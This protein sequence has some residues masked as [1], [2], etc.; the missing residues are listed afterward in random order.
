MY[1]KNLITTIAL[2]SILM[3][4]AWAQDE[5]VWTDRNTPAVNKEYAHADYMLFASREAALK[6]NYEDSENYILLNGLWNFN[7]ADDAR[8]LPKNFYEVNFDDSK[9]AKMQ[10]PS[11]W[12]INGYG[13]PIY[14]NS[15]FEFSPDS[16][17]NAP[18]FPDVVPGGQY[19]VKFN[20]PSRWDGR[21]VFIQ[22]GGVKSGCMVYVN[23][24]KVGYSEDSKDPAEFNITDY[25]KTGE[26]VLAIEVHRWS[27]GSYYE[28]QDFWRLSGIERDVYLTSRP[29]VLIRDIITES[30]LS[31]DYKDGELTYKVKLANYTGKANKVKLDLTVLDPA[32]NTAYT[33]S[34]TESIDPAVS[35]SNGQFVTF[36]HS[37]SNVK[38]WSAETPVLY[39]AL[40]AITGPDGKTEYTSSKIG[41]RSAFV[42]GTNFLVNGKRVM[43]KG[44]NIH[45]HSPYNG[46]VLSEEMMIKDFELMK[47]H[48][49]NAIRTSHYP[50]QRRFYE[51]CD[52]YGFYVCSEA[53][54]ESH[55]YRSV[56]KDE[57]FFPLQLE[58]ELNMYERTKNHAC[59]I[60][61]SLGNEAGNGVNFYKSYDALKAKEKMRP[62]V[63][64]DAGNDRNT[65]I[66]WPMY[67]TERS[68]L[69]TDARELTKPY[70]NCEYSHAMGN[71]N[72]DLYDLWEVYYHAKQLQGGFIWDWVDQGI[73]TN[74]ENGGFWAYGGDFGYHTPSDGNFCCNGLINPDRVPHPALQEVKKVYQNFLFEAADLEKCSI[75]ITNRHFFTNLDS[76]DYSYEILEDGKVIEKGTFSVP[77]TDP[78]KCVTVTVPAKFQKKAGK[79]YML[80]VYA[81]VRNE[82]KG[83]AKGLVV[84]YE[85]FEL[86]RE[87]EDA[88][89]VKAKGKFKVINKKGSTNLSV[90]SDN[91]TVTLDKAT[92]VV[93][94]YCIDGVEYIHEGFGIRPNFWR[95]TVDNDYGNRLPIRSEIWKNASK[96]P[97]AASVEVVKN[98]DKSVSIAVKYDLGEIKGSYKVCYTVF[99]DGKLK[100]DGTLSPVIYNVEEPKNPFQASNKPTLP[101]IGMRFHVPAEY[102]IVEYYGR[103]D[104]DNYWDRKSG[105]MVGLYKTTAEDMYFSYVRPQENGHRT[106]VRWVSLSNKNGKGLKVVAEDVIEFNA[107]RNSVED[108]DSA[109]SEHPVQLN[110]YYNT[111]VDV[112]NGRKQTH[113]NDIKPRDYVELCIDKIMMGVG[114]DNSWGAPV[115]EKYIIETYRENR[116][117]FTIVPVR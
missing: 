50:Q 14:I 59:V 30:P 16:G 26:N 64:G 21:Q 109:E 47:A 74:N 44:V 32:G 39:T 29:S 37:F 105:A 86:G 56:A 60:I 18:T 108:F 42:E 68:L 92:G 111:D 36:T 49:I 1:M 40:L 45:E 95:G 24:H 17:K 9:W 27:S 6:N 72:G 51:L 107:L 71:S 28:C 66:I 77:A 13:T 101:R 41:F 87:A 69:M 57:S 33:E 38:S 80:N 102:D 53:N 25:I 52:E 82:A 67:P 31:K 12:E 54:V 70:I 103:G 23:G 78:E 110:Y 46:H 104:F 81:S 5:S 93:T 10:V 91:V 20:V 43:I 76:F 117:S 88:V 79:E 85:Q 4:S 55:G 15:P 35:L 2:S 34:K 61:F 8:N 99:A 90:V 96:N 22:F 116:W 97:T 58:R 84:G 75:K 63:Y 7:Y 112:T 3:T 106:D 113:I 100:V 65:D 94:G 89:N 98:Q 62:V 83:L 115:N 73:W 114:G 48:N 11:N 19:R